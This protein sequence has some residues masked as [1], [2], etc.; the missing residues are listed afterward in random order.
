MELGDLFREAKSH[1]IVYKGWEIWL[2]HLFPVANGQRI[3]VTIESFDSDWGGLG[4]KRIREGVELAIDKKI[5]VAGEPCRLLHIW[6]YPPP[7]EELR[8]PPSVEQ[9]GLPLAENPR[10]NTYGTVFWEGGIKTRLCLWLDDPFAPVEV[11]CYTKDGHVH[12]ANAWN[13]GSIREGIFIGFRGAGM[14]VEEIE[15]GFRY[16]CNDNYPDEDFNDIVFRIERCE[17]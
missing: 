3:R 7:L 6:P 11:T 9:L 5:V 17:G 1:R 16:R 2:T 8:Q 12:V 13:M 10:P 4:E 15:G 14:M